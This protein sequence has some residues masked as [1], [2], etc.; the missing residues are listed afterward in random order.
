MQIFYFLVQFIFSKVFL[1]PLKMYRFMIFCFLN[2][3]RNIIKL[4]AKAMIG[5]MEKPFSEIH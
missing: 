3:S 1:S 2:S 5:T 4:N